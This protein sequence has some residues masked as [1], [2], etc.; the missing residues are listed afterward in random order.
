MKNT[1]WTVGVLVV[2]VSV[3]LLAASSAYAAT[4]T[5]SLAVTS[6]DSVQIN[7]IGDSNFPVVFYYNVGS[8]SG[9]NTTTL[10]STN[11]S[12][13]FSTTISTGAYA[14]N[15]SYPVYVV[16]DGQQSATQTW[17]YV[18][19]LPRVQAVRQY[20]ARQ[21]LRSVSGSQ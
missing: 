14:I 10:G 2:C 9:T 17:P 12:G 19:V 18:P 11:S 4:P 15:S 6:G 16:V 1:S 13:V 21:A 8:S 7:V 5:L 20:S 3:S